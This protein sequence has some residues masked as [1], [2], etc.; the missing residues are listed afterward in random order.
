MVNVLCLI[1]LGILGML[2]AA[3][4]VASNANNE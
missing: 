3:V 1:G 4:E 2:V